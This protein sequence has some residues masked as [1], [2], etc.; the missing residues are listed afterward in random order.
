MKLGGLSLV[1]ALG[2]C[3]AAAGQRNQTFQAAQD[4]SLGI[5]DGWAQVPSK[6]ID[7]RIASLPS[8]VQAEAR[9]EK[10]DY[11]FQ[12]LSRGTM[13]FPLI[14]IQVR[15]KGKVTT[16]PPDTGA[17]FSQ[18]RKFV[19]AEDIPVGYRRPRSLPG[20]QQDAA[21]SG[22][23][24]WD[25]SNRVLLFISRSTVPGGSRVSVAM[26]ICYTEKG[27]LRVGL[28]ADEAEFSLYLPVFR[29]MVNT[30]NYGPTLKYRLR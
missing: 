14:Q 1:V 5:P 8:S 9:R 21:E 17:T 28:S 24:E 15:N 11:L 19:E 29:Q 22:D 13:V 18:L 2:C 27:V 4:F 25:A 7:Q 26:A 20:Y 16:L 12:L 6:V 3:V 10:A 23:I 30:I